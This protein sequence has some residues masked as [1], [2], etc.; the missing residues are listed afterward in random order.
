MKN[1]KKEGK[2][3]QKARELFYR[4][5]ESSR[6]QPLNLRCIEY[7]EKS[8]LVFLWT[9][10]FPWNSSTDIYIHVSTQVIDKEKYNNQGNDTWFSIWSKINLRSHCQP[11]WNCST[12]WMMFVLDEHVLII[13]SYFLCRFS[14]R[15]LSCRKI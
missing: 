4:N 12:G 7:V 8:I 9:T 14:P 1:R 6:M 3:E 10:S 11:F 2:K 15:Y 5:V 13:F